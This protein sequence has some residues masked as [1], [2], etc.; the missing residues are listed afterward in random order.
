MST[1]QIAWLVLLAIS[2][3]SSL[4]GQS[5]RPPAGTRPALRR[6]GA[7]SILP[8]GRMIAPLG[9]QFSTGPG[10]WGL[11]IS[12]NGK[13][14]VTSDSGPN[15]Y[16]LSVLLSEKEGWRGVTHTAIKRGE[17]EKEA[18]DDF[19]SVFM[20]LTFDDDKELFA[21][22]GNS[23]N[24]RM[25]NAQN[26]H[27]KHVFKLNA[28][29]YRD[30]YSGDVVYDRPRGVLY[31][32]DQANFRVV[33][34]DVKK[35]RILSSTRVGRL[36]FAIG[37]SPDHKHVWV[38]NLG[39]FEYMAIPGADKRNARETG[40]PFPAFGFPSTE[41]L[42]G[43]RRPNGKGDMV[44]VPGLGDVNVQEANSVTVINVEQPDSPK[45]E[46]FIPTGVPFGKLSHGGSS[47]S[48][49][50]VTE[51]RAYVA[52]GNNDSI[53]VIDTK[54]LHVVTQ[55]E[56]RI[57]GLETLRGVLPTGL[58]V[59]GD[60]L[61]VA[62]S[63]INAVGVIDRKK[64]KVM[65]HLP[66]GWF[67][68]R[69]AV[70]NGMVFVSN[71][72]GNGTGPNA[73]MQRALPVSFQGLFR[74]GSVSMFP[75][76]SPSELAANTAKV[77]AL[78]GFLPS[79]E[80]DAP[81]PAAIKY[82]VMIV[83]EN[84]TFDEV[85]GDVEKASN[86]PVNGSYDLARFGTHGI[87]FA[88]KNALQKR[89]SMRNVNVTPNHHEIA[90]RWAMSDNFYADSE[91]SVDGHHWLVGSYPNAW[92]E[93]TLMAAYGGQK[94]F[95]FPSSAPGRYLFTGSNSSVHPEE[96][97]EA[98]AIW[99]H[100]DKHGV[101]FRNY[102]EGFELSGADEGE[103]LKPTGARFLTNVPMP[104]PLYRNTSRDY[105]NYNTNIPDQFRATQFIGEVERLYIRPGKE[106]PRFLFIHLPND[107]TA[108]PRP[109][110]GYPF[111]S[112][113]VADN[114]HALGRILEFLSKTPYWKQMAVFVTEDDA[115]GGVDHVDSHRTIMMVASPY[116]KK[117]YVSR[118]NSSFPGMLKT[119]F[120]LLGLPPLNL[121][122]ATAADLSECFTNTPDFAPY[123]LQAS[124]S[125]LFD[126]QKVKEPRD[127]EEGPKMDDPRFLREQH[128][129]QQP[130]NAAK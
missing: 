76:P 11:A 70:H 51:T 19:Y 112:S 30:S 40:L 27:T 100:M 97:L 62:E 29:N 122:D 75:L 119:V 5:W 43:A 77:M 2:A 26:G 41:A 127:G 82:V 83:K 1:R 105:P 48:G 108:K 72:K 101:T 121:Y 96:Q 67:P 120:R 84:R 4:L 47:P 106:L 9:R 12:P 18:D 42:V 14:V 34:L 31:V 102:G 113:Y 116:A 88:D 90:Q 7:E 81:L 45:V 65:G 44:A 79:K 39:M 52:N 123:Q 10:P 115:Q 68:T 54:T 36:P 33:A 37:L 69:I 71:A 98:G 6:P 74:R 17:K 125:E 104:D 73:N 46:A 56:I 20:G 99:H 3:S 64:D 15:K 25:L 107:H 91:V 23:G 28:N 87:I 60:W 16:S 61:L 63:G 109:E 129:K 80:K 55:I 126:P 24:V 53:T 35:R 58:T 21:S 85:F 110:D 32:V 94:D 95:R 130:P 111:V 66:V 92:T 50:A 93:S 8:G 57:P 117:N 86:G 118:V 59:Q 22:E 38:T 124:V 128:E 114:D 49:I 78:N 103:G 13:T 89:F